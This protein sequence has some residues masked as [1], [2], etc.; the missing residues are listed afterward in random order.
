VEKLGLI[1][2]LRQ[3]SHFPV[4]DWLSTSLKYLTQSANI[5]R[6]ATQVHLSFQCGAAVGLFLP[7]SMA[8]AFGG[9]TLRTGLL[10][11]SGKILL[12]GE[13]EFFSFFEGLSFGC[14][15]FDWF[16]ILFSRNWRARQAHSFTF[17]IT[18]N[19]KQGCPSSLKKS[20][21]LGRLKYFHF[22]EGLSFG[23]WHL[24][25]FGLLISRSWRALMGGLSSRIHQS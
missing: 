23:C 15:H 10:I 4:F 3:A 21:Y 12:S 6:V 17:G 24:D 5:L 14:W 1:A 19:T 2:P 18:V 13:V 20:P 22:F 9:I 25:W 8:C 16:S 11:K 7:R